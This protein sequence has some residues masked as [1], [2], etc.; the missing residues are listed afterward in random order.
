MTTLTGKQ[1]RYLRALGHSLSSVVQVGK[2]GV[3]DAL[4]QALDEALVTHELVKVKV[5]Q[6]APEGRHE[7]AEAM[8][9]HTGAQ[10]A[11][12]LGHTVL[13]YRPHPLLPKLELP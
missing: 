2:D 10:V 3:T 13:L 12:V 7:I 1:R 4:C 8:A 9:K 5:G 6:G 11:Q